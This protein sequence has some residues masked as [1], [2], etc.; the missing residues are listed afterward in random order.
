[1]EK[2]NLGRNIIGVIDDLRSVFR[3]IFQ[4]GFCAVFFG[5]SFSFL[6]Y[7]CSLPTYST[8]FC[9]FYLSPPL[10]LLLSHSLSRC[11]AFFTQFPNHSLIRPAINADSYF[12]GHRLNILVHVPCENSQAGWGDRPLPVTAR[13]KKQKQSKANCSRARLKSSLRTLE[14]CPNN[15]AD[16]RA[17]RFIA[18]TM[19]NQNAKLVANRQQQ[20]KPNNNNNENRKKA[21]SKHS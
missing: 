8:F 14:S 20:Q 7:L 17:T 13:K 3:S 15:V 19:Q 9:C 12:R 4:A 10:S 1:M 11:M 16:W 5:F 18:G 21:F 6:F 2:K